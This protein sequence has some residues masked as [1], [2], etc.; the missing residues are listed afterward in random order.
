[1]RSAFKLM[2]AEEAAFRVAIPAR[3]ASTRLP[4]KPLRLI[5]GRAMIEH[6]YDRAV[7]SG[8]QEVLI[9]TDDLRIARAAEQFG[10]TVC[11]TA[12]EHLS[13]TDRLAEVAKMRGWRDQDIIVNVQGD[14]PMI[15]PAAIRQVVGGLHSHPAADIATLCTPIRDLAEVF[16]PNV[17]KV[18]MDSEGYAMYFSRAPIPYHRADFS[19]GKVEISR[20]A[21]YYRH[22]GLYAY[23]ADIL[24]RY[25]TLPP[26]VLE[27]VE[28]LEQLRALWNGIRIHVQD[29]V[30]VPSAGVDTEADLQRVDRYLA[31]L[32]GS[33]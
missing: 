26:C 10:A 9:A 13:G 23:R 21:D 28:S 15:P 25:P 1:M 5:G 3:Y 16:D 7:A 17:V 30:E 20:D 4:G 24:R 18:V 33:K 2:A 11:M 14:E 19:A 8:A 27:K 22:I 6:V 31:E 29:A 12:T 32:A